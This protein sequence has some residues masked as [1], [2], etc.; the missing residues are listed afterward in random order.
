LF[1]WLLIVKTFSFVFWV[2]L[3]SKTF[4]FVFLGF[5]SAEEWR[6][7]AFSLD[8]SFSP[9]ICSSSAGVKS[10]SM[11]NIV[12][13]S[14]GVFPRIMKATFLHVKSSSGLLS[15]KLAARMS[16]KS[17]FCGTFTKSASHPVISSRRFSST[18]SSDR[19]GSSLWCRQYSMILSS[20][21]ADTLLR[22]KPSSLSSKQSSSI[23]VAMVPNIMAMAKGIARFWSSLVVT[24]TVFGP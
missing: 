9:R 21:A 23:K 16:S 17:S 6:T 22:G 13:I 20:T 7:Q 2:F 12:R 15:K 8:H 19:G 10:F 24:L 11:L 5:S 1:F 14:S 18:C 4:S 3:V